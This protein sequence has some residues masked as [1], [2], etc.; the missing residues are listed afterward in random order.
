M[1]IAQVRRTY[2]LSYEDRVAFMRGFVA[3]CLNKSSRV[4]DAGC[5]HQNCLIDRTEVQELIGVD[6]DSGA[7]QAN[8]SISRGIF[9]DLERLAEIDVGEKVDFVMCVDVVE[10]LRNPIRFVGN[11][12]K[13]LKV[14]GCFFIAA[15]NKIS[16][17]GALTAWLPT[18][19]IKSLS[20][21]IDGKETP[22]EAHYYRLNTVSSMGGCLRRMGF[23]DL[24]F[25]LL[26]PRMGARGSLRW[27][28]FFPD[29]VIGQTGL[30]KHYSLRILCLAKL[31][32]APPGDGPETNL[33]LSPS[34]HGTSGIHK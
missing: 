25:V 21:L 15:P 12:A 28:L 11:V 13:I 14:G 31:T 3:P 30:L 33:T 23:D 32:V 5:G 1:S 6:R 19:T 29:Y 34:H 2:A 22:N 4:L 16:M 27:F 7:I 24:Q 9:A 26:D 20:R 18:H 17:V 10:H 8:R